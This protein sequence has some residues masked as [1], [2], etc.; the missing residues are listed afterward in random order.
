MLSD[1]VDL[2]HEQ[3]SDEDTS[4]VSYIGPDQLKNSSESGNNK[5]KYD[6]WDILFMKD[7]E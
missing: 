5:G 4:I 7:E 6:K 1:V 3:E 2:N